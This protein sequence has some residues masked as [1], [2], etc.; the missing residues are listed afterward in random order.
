METNAVFIDE[1]TCIAGKTG[2]LQGIALDKK[3]GHIYWSFTTLLVKTDLNGTVIGSVGGL[4]GHLGCIAYCAERDELWGTLE[5]KGDAVGR[6]ISKLLKREN[7]SREAFYAV[8]FDIEAITS[9]NINAENNNIM[10]ACYLYDVCMDYSGSGE[11]GHPHRYGCSGIDGITFAPMIT[12]KPNAPLR[13]FVAY[14]IYGDVN[15]TD[16]DDQVIL[17]I[18]PAIAKQTAMKLRQDRPHR[19]GVRCEDK[20]FVKTGNTNYG[21]QNLEYDSPTDSFFAAVYPGSKPQYPN[22]PM[23]VFPRKQDPETIVENNKRLLGGLN[24]YSF[25]LGSTGLASLGNGEFL[26]SEAY[27]DKSRDAGKISRYKFTGKG[28]DGFEKI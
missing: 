24:S 14:G 9:K 28:P 10:R 21:I 22:P 18:D 20:L 15:R 12:E 6:G 11:N 19:I 8:V 3:R 1:T 25:P 5:L 26:V 13:M 4:I 16:N 7:V 27:R 2:H 23:F 17:S